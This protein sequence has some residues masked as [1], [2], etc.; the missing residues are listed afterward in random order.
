[1]IATA[2][3]EQGAT[4]RDIANSIQTAAGNTAKT[5]IEIKSVEKSAGHAVAA[6]GEISGWTVRLSAQA[7][8][9]EAKVASFFSRVRAA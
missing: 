2:V 8:D 7:Q 6:I 5:S 9:L 4:T 1:M 3:D